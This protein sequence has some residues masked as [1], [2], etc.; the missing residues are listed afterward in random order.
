MNTYFFIVLIIA[1]TFLLVFLA[2]CIV[3]LGFH[4]K[5]SPGYLRTEFVMK[6]I[7]DYYKK[8]GNKKIYRKLNISS[9]LYKV[10]KKYNLEIDSHYVNILLGYLAIEDSY[11]KLEYKPNSI[12][13]H[14]V[15]TAYFIKLPE[16][17]KPYWKKSLRYATLNRR[18]QT[19][20]LLKYNPY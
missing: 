15:Y 14:P 8:T 2:L 5:Y 3:Q 1:V 4:Y 18:K 9:Y 6:P 16:R 11:L 7:H 12:S 13:T 17:F 10:G 20:L 19:T